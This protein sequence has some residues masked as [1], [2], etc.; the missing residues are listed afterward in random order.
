VQHFVLISC[1]G[2][3]DKNQI[4]GVLGRLFDKLK[5]VAPEESDPLRGRVKAFRLLTETAVGCRIV[6]EK[7][8]LLG[9]TGER[10][11]A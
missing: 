2:W 5:R 8:D 1:K 4:I 10:F 3:I 11:K 7:S 9:A 6:L